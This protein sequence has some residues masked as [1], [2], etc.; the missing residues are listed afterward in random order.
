MCFADDS[1]P[2]I[3]PIAGG[4]TDTKDLRLTSSDG[5]KIM[6]YAARATS[7]TG[8]GMVVIP[9]VRGLH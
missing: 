2:P 8:A 7:P 3:L 1:R 4:A 5:T 6:A 9:D